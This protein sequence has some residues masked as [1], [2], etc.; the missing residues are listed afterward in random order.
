MGIQQPPTGRTVR[1]LRLARRTYTV[2][3]FVVLVNFVLELASGGTA[4]WVWMG[5]LA[6]LASLITLVLT[7][8]QLKR[9]K[10]PHTTPLPSQPARHLTPPGRGER[11]LDPE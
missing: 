6:F 2:S 11:R 1:Q 8:H 5:G 10:N 3:T 9:S 7:S 4:W